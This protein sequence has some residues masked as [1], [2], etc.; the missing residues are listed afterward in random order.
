MTDH[1]ARTLLG[2]GRQLLL[3]SC[4]SALPPLLP[5]AAAAAW[6]FA[7]PALL[8]LEAAKPAAPPATS[9]ARACCCLR[10]LLH[11]CLWPSFQCACWHCLELQP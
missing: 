11:S 10:S 3:S 4:R 5:L 7:W 1:V 9:L 8:P 2:T 6:P